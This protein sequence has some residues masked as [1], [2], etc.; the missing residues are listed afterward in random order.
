M[1][2]FLYTTIIVV[3][4]LIV[5]ILIVVIKHFRFIRYHGLGH[6]WRVIRADFRKVRVL[7]RRKHVIPLLILSSSDN[8][9]R[10]R[11]LG[12]L[13]KHAS[14]TS[15]TQYRSDYGLTEIEIHDIMGL[16]MEEI[17]GELTL[18]IRND[19]VEMISDRGI[20]SPTYV[21]NRLKGVPAFVDC[22]YLYSG[23]SKTSNVYALPLSIL[24]IAISVLALIQPEWLGRQK[25]E[26]TLME[27]EQ[28][29]PKPTLTNQSPAKNP[30]ET[31]SQAAST[32]SPAPLP[33]PVKVEDR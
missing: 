32:R 19:H 12:I 15:T 10:H 29:Y 4:I 33:V 30:S 17:D 28:E 20:K 8:I 16:S 11:L 22:E 14:N 1:S 18:L 21:I 5:Y 2:P 25:E 31:S 24:A 23:I 13:Y 9:R 7:W 26:P 3:A 6:A 27:V